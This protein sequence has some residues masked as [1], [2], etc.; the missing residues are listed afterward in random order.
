MVP[1]RVRETIEGVGDIFK[2]ILDSIMHGLDEKETVASIIVAIVLGFLFG[3]IFC[4]YDL[5]MSKDAWFYVFSALSQTLAAFIAFGAMVLVFRLGIEN[6]ERG[7]AKL[8]GEMNIPYSLMITSVVF[9]IILL[10]FGQINN[11]PNWINNDW[12][13]FLKYAVSFFT[14][15]LGILGMIRCAGDMIWESHVIKGKPLFNWDNVPGNDS[16]KLIRFLRCD[17]DI[18]WAK[19]AEICKSDDGKTISISIGENSAEITID[20]RQEKA[21]LKI[22]DGAP[23]YLKVKKENDKLNAYR[24]E[25]E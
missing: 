15:A 16:K 7:R 5:E 25:E 24:M 2:W 11:P 1:M 9:S 17:L 3:V 8:I 19:D 13:K 20:K 4:S 14:I 6:D 12:F 18:G 10:T 22:N 21:T 23:H